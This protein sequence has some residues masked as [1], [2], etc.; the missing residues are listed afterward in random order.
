MVTIGIT[1][2]ARDEEGRYSIPGLYLDAVRAAGGIPI[3]LTPGEP[4]VESLLS[5]V[6]GLLLAGGG[7]VN[8]DRYGSSGHPE[9]YAVDEDRDA[10]EFQLVSWALER[11]LPLLGICRGLQVINVALG[12]TLIEH[13]PDVIDDKTAH[14]LVPRAP[15][16]HAIELMSE[17]RLARI[18]RET[19]F[20]AASWHHQAIDN[21]AFGLTIVGRAPDGTIEALEMADHPELIAVQWHPEL[22]AATD[23][24][25]QRIFSG[26]IE[27][28]RQHT[29]D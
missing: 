8:P 19:N 23:S 21:V 20:S 3:L 24:I 27:L 17:S 18:Y 29:P 6:D 2:Y 14:C 5:Q 26:F 15:T 12:G 9:V 7:D 16:E 25:Q 10:F 4:Q 22:T 28:C 13:L 1:T 11:R